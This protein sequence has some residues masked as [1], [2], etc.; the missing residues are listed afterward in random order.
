M[1]ILAHVGPQKLIFQLRNFDVPLMVL[2]S[3]VSFSLSFK[4]EPYIQY[5]WKRVKRLLF[6][7]WIFL[8]I[9]FVFVKFIP[10]IANIDVNNFRTLFN[11][12]SLIGEIGYIWIIRVFLMIALVAPF[13][14]RWSNK[15][16]SDQY[17]LVILFLIL[18][19]YEFVKFIASIYF[20]GDIAQIVDSYISPYLFY[21][22]P[23][24]IIFALGLRINSMRRKNNYI[25][26]AFSLITFCCFLLFFVIKEQTFIPTQLY[27][28]PPSIYYFSYAVFISMSLWISS[29]NIW[30]YA[31]S[32]MK[33]NGI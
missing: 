8:T 10:S 18:L 19:L 31:N 15:I 22:I 3:G 28:F 23:Y 33:C 21:V 13:I 24:S 30:Q 11:A 1:I 16:K 12:Y 14:Y 7:T 20:K 5:V 9:Y 32:R 27:K 25:V 17:Y 6:P 2:L 4:S 29:H 26:L